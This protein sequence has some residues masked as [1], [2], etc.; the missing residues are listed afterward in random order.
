MHV[1]LIF[2]DG[3][4][5]GGID[6]AVNPFHAAHYPGW[7]ELFDGTMIHIGSAQGKS[8]VASWKGIDATLGVPGLPQSGTGQ[9]AILTGVNAPA[10]LGRHFGPFP[11]STLRPV[12]AERNIFRRL[13][14][15]GKRSHYANAFPG[16][17]FAYMER[18]RSRMSAI[19]FAWLST[20][21]S[22]NDHSV[23]LE[24][25]ALSAD[26]TGEGW[27]SLGYPDVP[28][29]SFREAAG[30]LMLMAS[31]FNFVL[32]EY[33]FT[34]HAGH[35]QSMV[36]ALK[37]LRIVDGLITAIL[38]AK[39]DPNLLVVITSDHGNIEDISTKSHTR[40]L[41]PFIVIGHGH[42][43]IAQN[44]T[45]LTDLARLILEIA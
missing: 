36:E 39:R 26:I 24:G 23:L 7:N 29:L 20:G 33:S 18:H 42:E 14:Q 21:A 40:N 4:G 2:L 41:V 9:T 45:D 17:Y 12:I 34:D 15:A 8:R 30:R 22:L 10:F 13:S 1:L 38:E 27:A 37:V 5:I 19:P 32:F 25:S 28:V 16:K 3:V 44:I 6:A 43:Q 35:S 31:H 11:F